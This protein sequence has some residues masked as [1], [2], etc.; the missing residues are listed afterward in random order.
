MKKLPRH[1]KFNP[2]IILFLIILFSVLIFIWSHRNSITSPPQ[3]TYEELNQLK[4]ITLSF[5]QLSDFFKTLAQKKGGEYAYEVLKIAPL[6]PNIDLHLLGH[7]VGDVLYKQKGAEGIQVCTNDF[8]N[9]CSHSIVIGLFS[10][11]GEGTLGEIS[12][13]C[14][15]APG[16]SGAYTMCFHGLGHGILTYTGYDMPKTIDIC[17]KTG[18]ST[19]HNREYIECVGGAVMEIIG[20]GFHDRELYEKQQKKYLSTKDPLSLCFAKYM[21][22]IVKPQCLIYLTPYLFMASG[23]DLGNPDPTYFE[24]SFEYCKQIPDGYSNLKMD[25]YNGFGKE[26]VGLVLSRDIR[27]QAV[28]ELNDKQLKTVYDWCLLAKNRDGTRECIVSAISSLYWGG[29]NRVE[30]AIKLCSLIDDDFFLTSCYK[31]LIVMVS[32]YNKDAV[33]RKA[34]CGKLPD[35]FHAECQAELQLTPN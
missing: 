29:E 7:V 33:Q 9:A 28:E 26:F 18:T 11:K 8:R 5:T 15:K 22:D 12:D 2:L 20:G 19:Y 13:A 16:G 34:F 21:P 6:N 31:N 10:E 14:H 3:K 30:P 35:N 17:K 24:K 27:T 4:G 32:S 23:A 1:N 25:C